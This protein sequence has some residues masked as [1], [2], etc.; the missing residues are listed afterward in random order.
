MQKKADTDFKLNIKNK[1]M[2]EQNVII[3][4]T[5]EVKVN[6]ELIPDAQIKINSV[7][8]GNLTIPNVNVT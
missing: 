4:I 5:A 2:N 6:G 3:E 8:I 7:T 1:T